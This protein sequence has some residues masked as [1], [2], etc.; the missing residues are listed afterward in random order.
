MEQKGKVQLL[1]RQG[2]GYA[3][4]AVAVARRSY[5]A[6]VR[7][8]HR[9]RYRQPDAVSSCFGVSGGIGTVEAVEYTAQL[10]AVYRESR[11]IDRAYPDGARLLCQ[12][13]LYSAAAD[14]IMLAY[15]KL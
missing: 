3:E 12:L 9:L 13:Q 2:H 7:L 11:G 15:I 10:L 1:H 6:A 14:I 4:I 5:P 8:C